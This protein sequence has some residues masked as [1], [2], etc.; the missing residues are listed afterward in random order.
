MLPIKQH[1]TIIKAMIIMINRRNRY[2]FHGHA[3]RRQSPLASSQQIGRRRVRRRVQRRSG[4]LRG[5]AV[6]KLRG[7]AAWP[8][9]SD[10]S[11]GW[12]VEIRRNGDMGEIM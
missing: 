1:P 8:K 3:L 11:A 9:G 4:E 7:P 2:V 10:E 5:A 6:G 12:K